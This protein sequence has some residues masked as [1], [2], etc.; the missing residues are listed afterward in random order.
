MYTYFF[1]FYHFSCNYRMYGIINIRFVAIFVFF[2]LLCSF[3]KQNFRLR[4]RRRLALAAIIL[5]AFNGAGIQCECW[6]RGER[7]KN[8]L[9]R[10]RAAGQSAGEVGR[11]RVREGA[12]EGERKWE[13][14]RV[15]K[16]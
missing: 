1:V 13:W 7:E 14:E 5:I 10:K 15:I 16:Q 11:V 6:L 12:R 4:R 8:A 2:F 9:I 3:Q